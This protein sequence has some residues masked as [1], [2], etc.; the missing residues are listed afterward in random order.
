MSG[1]SLPA[2]SFSAW[3]LKK[4]IFPCYILLPDQILLFGCLYSWDIGQYVY[5]N[6]LLAR[7]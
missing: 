6:Y 5:C 7:L 2:T 3:F 4:R 1:T